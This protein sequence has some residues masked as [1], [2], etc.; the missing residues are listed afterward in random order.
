M[1]KNALLSR[2]QIKAKYPNEWLLLKDCE[3]D[4][5]TSL[6]KGRV[7][8]HSKDRE[9]IHRAL[10]KHSGNLCIHFTGSLPPDTGVI[11]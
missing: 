2:E 9:E 8:A 1:A 7:L 4:A 5:S 6:R 10:R 3:L 11:F